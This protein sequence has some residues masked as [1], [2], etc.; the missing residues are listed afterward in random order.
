MGTDPDPNVGVFE[1]LKPDERATLQALS[2]EG[3]IRLEQERLP[4]SYALER[5]GVS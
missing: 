4:W 5:L 2:A 3:N 1:L